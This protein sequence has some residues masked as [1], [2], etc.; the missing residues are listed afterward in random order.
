MKTGTSVRAEFDYQE[1]AHPA[2]PHSAQHQQG[3]L[4]KIL[5]AHTVLL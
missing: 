3:G 2:P 4:I 5:A 1:E